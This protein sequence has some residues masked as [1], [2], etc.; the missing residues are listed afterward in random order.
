MER[1]VTLV[2]RKAR[3][4]FILSTRSKSAALRSPVRRAF[5]LQSEIRWLRGISGSEQVTLQLLM[6]QGREGELEL[7]LEEDSS[8]GNP[9][10]NVKK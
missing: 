1:T 5:N 6:G 8:E 2:H 4:E 9:M 10:Q 7:V 3:R